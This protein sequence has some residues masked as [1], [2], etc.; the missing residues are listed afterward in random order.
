MEWVKLKLKE[1][2]AYVSIVLAATHRDPR[3]LLDRWADADSVRPD[4]DHALELTLAAMWRE[5]ERME[6]HH[7]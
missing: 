3:V 6:S 5:P 7:E 1:R 4:R 2:S